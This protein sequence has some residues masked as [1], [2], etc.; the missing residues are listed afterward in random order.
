MY[1]LGIYRGENKFIGNIYFDYWYLNEI[2]S[3]DQI[4]SSESK[5]N[6]LLFSKAIGSSFKFIMQKEHLNKY[7]TNFK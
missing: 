7:D 5:K 1:D 6:T 4:A 2:F 3:I